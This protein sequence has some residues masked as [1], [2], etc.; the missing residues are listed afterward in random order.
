MTEKEMLTL[1]L[2]QLYFAPMEGLTTAL[3]RRIHRKHFAGPDV[4]YTPFLSANRTMAFKRRELRDILPENNEGVPLIPQILGNKADE[5]AWAV[6][7]VAEL[8][9]REINF[10]LGCP[11][12]QVAR[13]G[14]GSGFL[15]DPDE[16]DRF[17][18]M[19]FRDLEKDPDPALLSV[20]TRIGVSD[21]LMAEELMKIYNRYPFQQII[22][23]PRLMSDLYNNRPDLETFGRMLRASIHPVCYNGDI[24]SVDDFRKIQELF[25][26]VSEFMIGRGLL[27]NPSLA[28]EIK[29]GCAAG[30]QEMKA[31][32]DELWQAYLALFPDAR[33]AVA[34][35]KGIW[36]YLGMSYPE[37]KKELKK[38]KK[39][40]AADAYE[41]AAN[42]FFYAR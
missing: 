32:L 15:R 27:Q 13:R 18:D 38:I 33:Q 24:C 41:R 5:V 12:P 35:M 23:H 40:V 3:Y 10:N 34:K 1:P 37:R 7:T 36:S 8:G 31:F 14:K 4:Y 21:A 6:R 22:I 19:L 42:E 2:F 9:W 29:G 39:A 26:E 28:E 30:Q 20:K 16:L 25:P 11:M 17:F